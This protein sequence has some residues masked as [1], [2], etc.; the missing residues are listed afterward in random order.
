MLPGVTVCREDVKSPLQNSNSSWQD[1]RSL[2]G[3]LTGLSSGKRMGLGSSSVMVV[4]AGEG[5]GGKHTQGEGTEGR[6]VPSKRRAF[7][8]LSPG[9]MCQ[10]QPLLPWQPPSSHHTPH[11]SPSPTQHTTTHPQTQSTLH[12]FTASHPHTHSR[13]HSH[14]SLPTHGLTLTL[15]TH[16]QASQAKLQLRLV[17]FSS[18]SAKLVLKGQCTELFPD[19]VFIQ[20]EGLHCVLRSC[21]FSLLLHRT[22][23]S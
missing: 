6:N 18:A 17:E 1:V 11:T 10:L 14:T 21:P 23:D 2:V 20:F 16:T 7:S 15:H 12:S 4:R 3:L 5:R 8:K 22:V 13:G 9:I 19:A